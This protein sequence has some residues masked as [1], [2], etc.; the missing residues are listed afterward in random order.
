MKIASEGSRMVL[1]DNN[2]SVFLMGLVFLII[3]IGV[4]VALGPVS[5]LLVA[6]GAVFALAGLY[7]LWTTK[8]VTIALDKG[9]GNGSVSLRGIV[10]KESREFPLR[11]V[12][13]VKLKKSIR[14]SSK[15]GTSY[16]YTISFV[17]EGGE[18]LPFELGTVSAGLTDVLVSPDEKKKEQAKTVADFLG[19]PM[20]FED[21]P[22]L[23]EALGAIKE[24]I[25]EGMERVSKKAS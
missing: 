13:L 6:F 8:I 12:R 24:G 2:I 5:L 14:R 22:G 18:E 23:M 16:E 25:A 15:G 20:K 10:R 9:S 21:A 19:V 11:K 1:K 7:M 3:G 17:L 4:I